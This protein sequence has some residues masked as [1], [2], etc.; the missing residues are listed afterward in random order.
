MTLGRMYSFVGSF[1]FVYQQLKGKSEA[2]VGRSRTWN[3]STLSTPGPVAKYSM[4]TLLSSNESGSL[5]RCGLSI[6]HRKDVCSVEFGKTTL[7]NGG[8]VSYF[9]SPRLRTK[10]HTEFCKLQNYLIGKSLV[11]SITLQLW[12]GCRIGVYPRVCAWGALLC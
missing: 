4:Q 7:H 12:N 9:F 3:K 6:E 1:V 5:V 11:T 2:T 10:C 8:N